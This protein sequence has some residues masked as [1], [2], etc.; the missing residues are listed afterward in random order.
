MSKEIV[1]SI[2]SAISQNQV[3][4]QAGQIVL[5]ALDD[6]AIAGCQGVNI[7]DIDSEDIT[8]AAVLLDAS[9]SMD[10][11][12]DQ[13]I[14]A[15]NDRFLKPLQKAKNAKSI[16]V[17]TWVFSDIGGDNVRL[18]H[19]FT[20]IPDCP[21][22]TKADYA[23]DG[24]TPLNDAVYYGLTGIL[25]YGQTLRDGGAR[26]KCIVVVLTDGAE[27]ASKTSATKVRTISQDL[28]K[29]EIY[30]LSYV[31]FGDENEAATNA[32][33]IGFPDN[34]MLTSNKDDAAIRRV[35]G[36]VSASFISTSQS[37]VPANSLSANAFF[38]NGR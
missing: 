24:Q 20:A 1:V 12:R 38:P 31:F 36:E 5:E 10:P 16:L 11:Y 26:T 13:V 19:G 21:N 22:L 28:L 27:N 2:Q 33:K 17:S 9:G 30:V 23:P 15:Y 34:H 4:A 8:I 14:A 32:K 25:S 18:I 37:K 29:Q 7:D 35:F 3:S 6:V